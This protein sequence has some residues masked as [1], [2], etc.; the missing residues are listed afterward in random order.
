MRPKTKLPKTLLQEISYLRSLRKA[1]SNLNKSNPESR[2]ISG[3]TIRAFQANL[4]NNLKSIQRK[5]RKKKYQ[6]SKLRAIAIHKHGKDPRPLRIAEIRDR[7]VLKA[8]SDKITP[9]LESVYPINNEASFAY[10]SERNIKKAFERIKQ[11]FNDGKR[12]AFKTD[13]RKFFDTVNQEELLETKIFTVLPDHS[14]NELLKRGLTL[15]I[16]NIHELSQNELK[17]FEESSSGIPQGN[18]L[19]PLLSNIFLVDFDKELLN[20]EYGLV[21]YA[22]DLVV[23]CKDEK[24]AYMVYELCRSLLKEKGLEIHDLSRKK[25][26]KTK[27]VHPTQEPLQFLSICFDGKNLWPTRSKYIDL[28]KKIRDVCDIRNRD[29]Q[30]IPDLLTSCEHLLRGWIAAF[31]FTNVERYFP[32][33][34]DYINESLSYAL[35]VRDWKLKKLV[36]DKLSDEQRLFSGIPLCMEILTELR[37]KK[38][39]SNYH[40]TN[41]IEVKGNEDNILEPR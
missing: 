5:L 21:R 38:K 6:F 2:G 19:S 34:D 18:A 3:I 37:E 24:E 41:N 32:K 10:L 20:N 28:R 31:Y 27:I 25:D 26:S 13:I 11:L 16:G 30:K 17:Y 4:D 7:V 8:I 12:I 1:W 22:D 9:I 14:L 33:I 15:E 23:M 36:D 40:L 29:T 35:R 39:N